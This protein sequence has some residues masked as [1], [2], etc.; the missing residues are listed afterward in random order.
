MIEAYHKEALREHAS[1]RIQFL[2]GLLVSFPSDFLLTLAMVDEEKN[3][4]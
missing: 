3:A 2:L 1:W 4:C